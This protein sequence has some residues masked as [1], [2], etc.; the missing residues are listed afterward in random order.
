MACLK[1]LVI[2]ETTKTEVQETLVNADLE[3]PALHSLFY[4]YCNCYL[5]II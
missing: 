1:I 5:G 4:H 2:L 3:A